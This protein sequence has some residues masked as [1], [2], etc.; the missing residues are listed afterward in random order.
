MDSM[1]AIA[2]S[3]HR[4]ALNAHRRRLL[5][6]AAQHVFEDAG[7]EGASIR[8]IAK[9]AGCTTGAIYPSF[10]GKE[11]IFA[12]VLGRSLQGLLGA[13]EDA[14][15]NTGAAAKALRRGTVAFYKY[16]VERPSELALALYLFNGIRPR[17]LGGEL[18]SELTRQLEAVLDKFAEKIREASDRPFRPIVEVEA[19]G[20]FT[21]LV[22]LLILRHNGRIQ[23]LNKNAAVLLAHYTKNLLQ[24]L[25]TTRQGA[26]RR[27]TDG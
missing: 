3:S 5:V 24:R 6:D 13:V 27:L 18:D 17:K 25:N 4:E 12:A 8:S 19:M 7:L 9:A 14:M 2:K 1:A 11:D 10:K 15:S 21:Y 26:R 23:L 16:Y 20:L 22:G